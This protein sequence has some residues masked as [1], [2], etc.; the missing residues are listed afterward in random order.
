MH[1][2]T[3]FLLHS[4]KQNVNLASSDKLILYFQNLIME[5]DILSQLQPCRGNSDWGNRNIIS[6][7]NVRMSTDTAGL[8]TLPL[9]WLK[10]EGFMIKAP[11]F[12]PGIERIRNLHN[13]FLKFFII[14]LRN[15]STG[16]A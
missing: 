16:W 6:D 7:Q 12:M 4:F 15:L 11:L 3:I 8:N 2:F 9:P 1:Y 10:E 14:G 5:I 13:I